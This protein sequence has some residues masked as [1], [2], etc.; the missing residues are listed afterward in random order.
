MADAEVTLNV[1][2]DRWLPE[3]PERRIPGVLTWDERKGATLLLHEQLRP[4]DDAE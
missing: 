3:A 1:M 2:G 4:G